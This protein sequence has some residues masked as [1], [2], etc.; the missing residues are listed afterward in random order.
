MSVEYIS[1]DLNLQQ[2]MP[3]TITRKSPKPEP[4]ETQVP[5]AILLSGATPCYS[6]MPGRLRVDDS[7]RITSWSWIDI[8]CFIVLYNNRRIPNTSRVTR[9]HEND[10]GYFHLYI[11]DKLSIVADHEIP[12]LGQITPKE[13]QQIDEMKSQVT[14]H[15]ESFQVNSLF[16]PRQVSLYQKQRI[17]WHLIVTTMVC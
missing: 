14:T 1:P 3:Q 10:T 2:H 12:L 16:N 6:A 13:I 4:S 5:K 15:A 11:H 9:E 8:E 17:F 7:H